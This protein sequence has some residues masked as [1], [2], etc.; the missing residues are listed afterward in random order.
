MVSSETTPGR[1]S[2]PPPPAP[3]WLDWAW[4]MESVTSAFATSLWSHTGVPPVVMPTKT[5][6]AG[7]RGSFWKKGMPSRSMRARF[8]RPSFSSVS[9]SDMGKTLP[10]AQTMRASLMPC[11]STASST[12]GS[13]FE[14]GVGRN[15]LSMMMARLLSGPIICEKGG[16][17]CGASSAAAQ[18]SVGFA[19][20]AGSLGKSAASRLASGMSRVSV[21]R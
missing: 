16:P 13:S 5:Y 21:S 19:M 12:A 20:G 15:W 4:P 6:C 10:L 9:R 3:Q 7:S 2:L 17:E 8:S 18:A 14:V 1:I 11:A